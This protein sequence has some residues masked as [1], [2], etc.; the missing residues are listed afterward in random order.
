[1]FRVIKTIIFTAVAFFTSCNALKCVSINNQECK[2]R[3]KIIN[4][5]SNEPSFYPY[6][7]LLNK[8]RGSCHDINDPYAKLCFPDV[9]KNMNI[10]V[11]N[12][13]KK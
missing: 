12:N 4:I 1:M 3:L 5:N 7:I 13:V 2:I 11:L 8:C 9:F 6:S 10:K